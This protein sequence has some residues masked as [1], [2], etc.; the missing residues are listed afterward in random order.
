MGAMR[1]GGGRLSLTPMPVVQVTALSIAS[2]ACAFD[3]RTRRIPNWLT[4]GAAGAALVFHCV[5][6]G[7]SGVVQGVGGWAT[8]AALLLPPYALGG[9]GAGDVKLVGALGA[10]LGPGDTFWLAMYTGIAGGVMALAVSVSHGYLG[11]A[12]SNI[13]LLLTHWR[14]NGVGP[15]PELTLATG[16]GPRLAYAAPILVGTIVT[17]WLR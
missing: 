2:L 10:W 17:L 12:C 14:V 11:R 3:L 1:A 5:T 4:F 16:R 7:V 13:W 6:G 8:G 9:M 15:L